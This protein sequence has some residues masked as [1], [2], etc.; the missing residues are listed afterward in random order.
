MPKSTRVTEN[1]RKQYN[2]QETFRYTTPDV[3]V[4]ANPVDAFIK[5]RET[6][7]QGP[8]EAAYMPLKAPLGVPG[9]IAPPQAYAP[10][11]PISFLQVTPEIQQP[12]ALMAVAQ[13]VGQNADTFMKAAEKKAA[14]E[15]T[16]RLPEVYE[17][18]A[19]GEKAETVIQSMRPTD[20]MGFQR[21]AY[22]ALTSDIAYMEVE[23]RT[24]DFLWKNPEASVETA[25]QFAVGQMS[26]MG[27]N[28]SDMFKA[29]LIEKTDTL[30]AAVNKHQ[31]SAL[32]EQGKTNYL[33]KLNTVTLRTYQD[34]QKV[35]PKDQ[36]DKTFRTWVTEQQVKGMAWGLSKDD[37]TKTVLGAMAVEADANPTKYKDIHS[38]LFGWTNVGDDHGGLVVSEH[39]EYK[40]I[41]DK[42]FEAHHAE[43]NQLRNEAEQIDNDRKKA[44]FENF[45]GQLMDAIRSGK[46]VDQ[47]QFLA[48]FAKQSNDYQQ[49]KYF[50][51]ALEDMSG[52][53][54]GGKVKSDPKVLDRFWT[55]LVNGDDTAIPTMA[56]L[57]EAY[58]NGQIDQGDFFQ[59]S[60]ARTAASEPYFKSSLAVLKQQ[61]H[62]PNMPETQQSPQERYAI[63]AF[64]E[65][66]VALKE[67][68]GGAPNPE[69]VQ[70]LLGKTSTFIKQTDTKDYKTPQEL[71]AVA[72]PN[73]IGAAKA[74]ATAMRNW[75]WDETT[76]TKKLNAHLKS[77]QDAAALQEKQQA[78]KAQSEKKPPLLAT[79]M[80]EKVAPI[81]A[82]NH[83]TTN[84]DKTWWE[85][86][87][88]E[89]NRNRR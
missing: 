44:V 11:R 41:I 77:L 86:E 25:M 2:P 72:N 65:Q 6:K 47:K 53:A 34:Y 46:Q 61:F 40:Q 75:G 59:L 87:L 13:W 1:A 54:G 73:G 15:Q 10:M 9:F 56:E 80:I 78:V 37:V 50:K 84:T 23:K 57:R 4:V 5:Q 16:K 82:E 52:G 69:D 36:A 8:S 63:N 74:K 39:A 85:K 76:W 17:R 32:R 88:E 51:T 31:S 89:K 3:K 26:G 19:K 18:I 29:R 71:F 14:I 81:L 70:N 64:T 66:Y 35:L 24:Q 21:D 33:D 62:D 60:R 7:F 79:K 38:E 28:Q 12:S 22:D 20:F 55:P 30:L 67:K 27:A 48:N 68:H 42:A 58:T 83:I 43:L 49:Y 45:E